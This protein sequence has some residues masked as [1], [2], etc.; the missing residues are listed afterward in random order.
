MEDGLDDRT[1]RPIGGK[2]KT[3]LDLNASHNKGAMGIFTRTGGTIGF[4]SKSGLDGNPPFSNYQKLTC[5]ALQ[6]LWVSHT[7]SR[8][9][10]SPT[11]VR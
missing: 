9:P 6:L 2:C 1:T 3:D 5:T 8:K 10:Q 7:H 4:F 11:F